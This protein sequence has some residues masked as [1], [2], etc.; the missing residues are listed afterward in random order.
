MCPR[1]ALAAL[2]LIVSGIASSACKP[3][4][5]PAA[6]VPTAPTPPAATAPSAPNVIS[7]M[8]GDRQAVVVF[9]APASDG[10]APITSY[11]VVASPGGSR[12]SGAGSPISVSGLANGTAYTFRVTAMN[13][14]GTSPASGPSD[15][16]TPAE[17]PESP[18]VLSTS[19][20]DLS[21][22][23]NPATG[24]LGALLC[25]F[26]FAADSNDR[27]C[28]GAF[29]GTFAGGKAS[30]SYDYKVAA[31]TAGI[32][33]SDAATW[34]RVELQIARI[35][36]RSPVILTL[37]VCPRAFGTAGFNAVHDVAL[38]AHNAANPAFASAS[39]C[40]ADTVP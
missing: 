14:A 24:R 17:P 40:V 11:T 30:P 21:G 12:A 39:V 29:G 19:I 31:G 5:G 35:T 4:S 6:A 36:Q 20:V 1:S 16:V 25:T 13:S 33:T 15:V 22:A 23:Y 18:P 2:L 34:G 3:G 7:V 26:R 10:G 28:F 32:H 38:A 27:W 9:G 37:S 8:A